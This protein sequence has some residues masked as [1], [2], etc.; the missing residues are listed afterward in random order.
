[1]DTSID[2]SD[3]TMLILADKIIILRIHVYL[4]WDVAD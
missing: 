2:F 3:N 4:G 1:M